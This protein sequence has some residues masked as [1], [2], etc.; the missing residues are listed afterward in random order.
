VTDDSRRYG[1]LTHPFLLSGLSYHNTTSPIHRGVFLIRYM[2][3]RTLRPPN[4][5]FSPISPDLHPDLT[6]RQRVSLQTSS[7]NCQV[8]HVKING[9]GFTLENFDAVGRY[10]EIEKDKPIDSSGR[11]TSRS[12]EEIYFSGVEE[13]SKYLANSEDSHRAFVN[14]AFQYFVKQPIAAYGPTML[15]ELTEKFKSSGLNIRELII[16]I[17]LIASQAESH[18]K[19]KES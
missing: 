10:R 15:D 2:L 6:T 16:E 3:G 7:D 12:S 4:E 9:L 17:A 1:L 11:Y 13:L 5:A 8:C 18:F 14:R 19:N